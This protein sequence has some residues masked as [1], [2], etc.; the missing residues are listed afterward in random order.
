MF[1]SLISSHILQLSSQYFTYTPNPIVQ[2]CSISLLYNAISHTEGGVMSCS[3]HIP[4]G[5]D[6]ILFVDVHY[7]NKL[8]II[9]VNCGDI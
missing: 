4:W 9:I 7:N 8:C 6:V 1:L 3:I 2:S 5:S